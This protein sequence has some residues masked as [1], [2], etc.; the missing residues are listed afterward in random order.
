[1]SA[2]KELYQAV[3]GV[4]EEK[5]CIRHCALYNS[6]FDKL[7]DEHAFYFPCVFI[8]F[9]EMSYETKQEGVQQSEVVLRLHIGVESLETEDLELFDIIEDVHSAVQ[10]FF[11]KG[12][13]DLFTPLARLS[14]NQD[15]NHDNITVWIADYETVL[16]DSSAHRNNGLVEAKIDDIGLVELRRMEGPRLMRF[17]AE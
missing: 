6:Q 11:N 16:H 12:G 14:E 1:M 3:K 5:T 17:R 15:T 10:G 7:E 2:K 13:E 8:Q 9:L 4:I